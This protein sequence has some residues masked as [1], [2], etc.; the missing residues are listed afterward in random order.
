MSELGLPAMTLPDWLARLLTV[1]AWLS[2]VA[3]VVAG[4]LLALLWRRLRRVSV[5]PGTGF[6][7]TLRLVPIGLP[8]LLDLLDLALDV[9]SAP[10][11]WFLLDRL[12]LRQLRDVSTIEAVIPFTGP[13]PLLTICWVL[14]RLGFGGT[15]SPAGPEGPLLE[16]EQ[17]E[18]GR[19]RPR[20]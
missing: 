8:I 17:V 14:A 20:G 9:F 10:I 12:R 1:M 2:L 7:D 19:W 16:G 11:I 5:A 15:G 18:P 6:W 13:L 3:I 4:V